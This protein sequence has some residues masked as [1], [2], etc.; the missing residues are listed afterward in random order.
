M[1]LSLSVLICEMGIKSAC[2]PY[3]LSCRE[4]PEIIAEKE[5]TWELQGMCVCRLALPAAGPGRALR[6][7]KRGLPSGALVPTPQCKLSN[8]MD[9]EGGVGEKARPLAGKAV[10]A[11]AAGA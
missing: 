2:S 6:D 4:G 8:H 3:V 1:C 7:G 10:V 5:S 11:A 9:T